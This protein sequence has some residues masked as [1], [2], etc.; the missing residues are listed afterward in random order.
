M[1]LIGGWFGFQFIVTLYLQQLRGWSA[2]QTGLA[3]FPGGL[4][5]AL[6]A[7][8][9]AP[10]VTRFGVTRL[11]LIGLGSTA[12]AYTLFLPVDLSSSYLP[13]MLPTFLLVGLGFGL[14]YGP[15]NIA[16]PTASRRGSRG[17]PEGW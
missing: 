15:L 7:P 4:L 12:V 1:M 16:A 17:W 8:R 10:L 13:S 5:V 11:I 2:L 14:A 6:L 9:V 3:I